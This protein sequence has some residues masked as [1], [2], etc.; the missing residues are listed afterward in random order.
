MKAEEF[1]KRLASL[2]LSDDEIL[3]RWKG[4]EWIQI[5]QGW[6]VAHPRASPRK[7]RIDDE[8]VRLIDLYD[9]GALK[10]CD[11]RFA[12]K[13]GCLD[14][15]LFVGFRESEVLCIMLESREVV[16]CDDVDLTFEID[17][18]ARN[19]TMFLDAAFLYAEGVESLRKAEDV[20]M[21]RLDMAN[22]C[23][24]AAG[25]ARYEDC[26]MRLIGCG[27]FDV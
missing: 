13:T 2:C 22:A 14:D 24:R 17:R 18:V 4:P 26:W 20:E 1:V 15:R 27:R 21:A 6:Y 10:V 3:R 7:S 8:V 23:V 19:G 12:S 16:L 11:F 5:V 25:G 9:V